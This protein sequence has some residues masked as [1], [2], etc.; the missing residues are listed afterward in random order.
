M[1]GQP[2]ERVSEENYNRE[3]SNELSVIDY[4]LVRAL[5]EDD[6]KIIIHA[7]SIVA[8]TIAWEGCIE[9]SINLP[10]YMASIVKYTFCTSSMYAS[11]KKV[12][13][14]FQPYLSLT[15]YYKTQ[16]LNILFD[17]G[18]NKWMIKNNN[19]SII[20]HDLRNSA[21][22]PLFY[23]LFQNNP[24]IEQSYKKILQ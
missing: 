11:N 8:T 24:L 1:F 2:Q 14:S 7:D 10:E 23:I 18:I 5:G 13:A 12:Y 15:F 6:S 17:Y 16:S 21:L 22:L 20:C 4:H 3:D 19:G 9:E